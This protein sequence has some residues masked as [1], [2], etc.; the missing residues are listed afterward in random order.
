MNFVIF[1][2]WLGIL[3]L[4]EICWKESLV[5]C[6]KE[7]IICLKHLQDKFWKIMYYLAAFS[8]VHLF[9]LI[10]ALF[11]SNR[12]MRVT[13]VLVGGVPIIYKFWTSDGFGVEDHS[14]ANIILALLM[15]NL[16][17]S[18]YMWFF[19]SIKILG[20]R[21]W[22]RFLAWISFWVLLGWFLWFWRVRGSC[23]RWGEGLDER[24]GYQEVVDGAGNG[25]CKWT[26][27]KVCWGYAAEGVF[28]F[29]FWQRNDC[30]AHYSPTDLRMHKKR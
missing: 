13:G 4:A 9:I 28:S 15:M 19:I 24:T 23:D 8:C 14:Q 10:H 30:K 12:L 5:T 16:F 2:F 1:L 17:F 26:Q 27:S 21:L 7:I 18:V 11:L 22:R 6:E 20:K 29:I 25:V 3:Y